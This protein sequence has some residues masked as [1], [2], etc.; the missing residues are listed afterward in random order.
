MQIDSDTKEHAILHA[1]RKW[2]NR[3]GA[4]AFKVHISQGPLYVYPDDMVRSVVRRLEDA[5]YAERVEILETTVGY[6]ITDHGLEELQRLGVP[7]H[8]DH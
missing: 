3:D 8:Y 2:A 4:F 6:K 5:G 1:V 7:G